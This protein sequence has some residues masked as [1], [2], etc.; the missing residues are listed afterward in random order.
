[1]G[2]LLK[3]ID[4]AVTKNLQAKLKRARLITG[5]LNRV[6]YPMYQNA[7]RL[8]W[9]SQ[10]TSEGTQWAEL[11]SKSYIAR[12]AIMFASF[13][14]GGKELM[15]ASGTLFASVTGDDL[16]YHKKIIQGN[17]MQI[18]TSVPYAPYA[19]LARNFSKLGQNTLDSM[20]QACI[21]YLT[22]GKKA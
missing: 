4:Q 5:F 6:I 20:K 1:M 17:S 18:Y 21:D 10:N 16:T 11:T 14:G 2:E 19:D 15:I 8:R 7:Q 12:K 13:P 3:S 9:V 22:K